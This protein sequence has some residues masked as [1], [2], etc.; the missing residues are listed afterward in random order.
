VA[1]YL[2]DGSASLWHHGYTPR[3]DKLHIII[4]A[5]ARYKAVDVKWNADGSTVTINAPADVETAG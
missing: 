4:N 2:E 5:D 1:I 3:A